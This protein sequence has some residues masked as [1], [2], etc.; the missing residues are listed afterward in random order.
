MKSTEVDESLSTTTTTVLFQRKPTYFKISS[1]EWEIYI[2]LNTLCS[3]FTGFLRTPILVDLPVNL[4]LMF[5][6]T[7]L[8][9]HVFTTETTQPWRTNTMTG[10][11]TVIHIWFPGFL[12]TTVKAYINFL[13]LLFSLCRFRRNRRL[14]TR[15]TR[16][17]RRMTWSCSRLTANSRNSH[18]QGSMLL[19]NFC[20]F[21]C[22]NCRCCSCTAKGLSSG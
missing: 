22:S 14:L 2:K 15:S 11:Q 18:K 3:K 20:C 5:F 16:N 7:F 4:I 19:P 17:N 8:G 10:C 1:T 21:F 12:H 9:F 6:D 13:L